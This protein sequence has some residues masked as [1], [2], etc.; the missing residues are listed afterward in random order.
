LARP[1]AKISQCPSPFFLLIGVIAA[2]DGVGGG[3]GRRLAMIAL[4]IDIAIAA[5]VLADGE[6][7]GQMLVQIL[8]IAIDD[9]VRDADFGLTGKLIRSRAATGAPAVEEKDQRQ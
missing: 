8:V 2:G 4:A 7:E 5:P 9:L 6:G 1:T 3:L